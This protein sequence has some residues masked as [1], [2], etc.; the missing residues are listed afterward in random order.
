MKR[1]A[2][3]AALA[4]LLAALLPASGAGAE[5][6]PRI[7]LEKKIFSETA[8]GKKS[9]YEVHTVAEGEN[10]WKILDRRSPTFPRDYS[11]LLREFRRANPDV[12]DPDRL[13]PGQKILV[14]SGEAAKSRRIV[15]TGKAVPYKV[16]RGDALLRVLAARGVSRDETPRYLEAVRDLNEAVRDINRIRAGDTLLLPTAAYFAAPPTVVQAPPAPAGPAVVEA[17]PVPT[18]PAVVEAPPPS[19]GPV[20]A[21][22]PPLREKTETKEERAAAEIPLTQDVPPQPGQEAIPAARPETQ[23]VAPPPPAAEAGASYAAPGL[24]AGGEPAAVPAPKPL[25]RGLLSDIVAGLG[26]Q[27][28]DRGTLYLPLPSGGEVVLDLADYPVARFSTGVHALV[29]FRDGLP[30]DVRKVITETWKNYRVVPLGGTS[31]PLE[32]VDR[33]LREAGYHSAKDGTARPLVIGE[34]V[35]VEIPANWVVLRTDRSLLSGEVLLVK[36][37]PE[38]PG[39]GLSAVLRYAARVGVRVLPFAADRSAGEGF[40]VGLDPPAADEIP[41]FPWKSVPAGGLEAVDFALEFAGIGKDKGGKVVIGGKGGAFRLTLVPERMFE[42]AGKGYVVDTGKMT[43]ALRSIVQESG[44]RLFSV[45]KEEAGR[46]IVRRV[47]AAAGIAVEDRKGFLLAGGD[48]HG[49]TVRLT[50]ALVAPSERIAGRHLHSVA[51][52]RGKVH[53]ATRELMRVFGVEIVEW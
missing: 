13:H 4:A 2:A 10:L 12:R 23:F 28:V 36:E 11:A 42:A 53:A 17:P 45:G 43:P 30:P 18:G 1:T 34:D 9:F 33:L 3:A 14:P 31:G 16:V 15:D 8:E 21:A 49:F 37:V 24:A 20:V 44:H 40:L 19:A 50:G 25:Y 47:F 39:P 41:E 6:M 35:S 7:F 22:A 51:F 29:D 48:A 26:E 5:E 38:K 52:V 27:W 32:A 46:S